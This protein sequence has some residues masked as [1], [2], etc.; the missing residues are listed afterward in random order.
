M[1][2]GGAI[3][4]RYARAV[5]GL[6][7]AADLLSQIDLLTGTVTGSPELERALFTPI[8]PRAERRGLI[9][10]LAEKLEIAPEMRTFAMILVD[11]NRV[12]LLPA[13]RDELRKQVQAAAGQVDAELV[14]ARA[15]DESEVESIRAALSQRVNAQ[16]NLKVKV[17]ESL[18]GGVVARVGDLLLDGSVKTQLGSLAGSLEKGSR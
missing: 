2:K 1:I 13:I 7:D 14:S 16:V 4:R 18:I 11:E 5:F 15:L 9:A 6:G 12:A 3:A 10:E 8:H 17:D